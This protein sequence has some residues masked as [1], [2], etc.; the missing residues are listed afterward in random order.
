MGN[1]GI[2]R[3]LLAAAVHR[4]TAGGANKTEGNVLPGRSAA[5]R[6]P[7]VT[8]EIDSISSG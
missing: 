6:I 3:G 8:L 5:L 4:I 1:R 7:P 2:F